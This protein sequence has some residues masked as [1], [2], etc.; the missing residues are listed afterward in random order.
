MRVKDWV[1]VVL[2]TEVLFGCVEDFSCGLDERSW[3]A[4]IIAVF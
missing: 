3:F 2:F 4:C 1:L